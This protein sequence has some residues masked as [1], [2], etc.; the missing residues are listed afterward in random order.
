M[1]LTASLFTPLL[2]CWRSMIDDP[3]RELLARVR[4]PPSFRWGAAT[5]GFQ[6]EGGF[7]VPDGPA[8]HWV[9]W[10]RA[11]R[12]ELAGRAN[13]FW[14]RPEA[15]LDAARAIG[16][17]AFRLSLEWARLE[18]TEG[19]LDDV[20]LDHYVAIVAACW[21]R[22][23]E[24]L[25]TL[26]HFTHPAWLGEDP[27]SGAEG[28]RT[29]ARFADHVRL[30]ADTVGARL[31]G[32]GLPPLGCYVTLNEI[33]ILPLMS[34]VLGVF[35][36]GGI[37]HT[38]RAAEAMDALLCAHIAA[39]DAIHDVHAARGWPAP[40]VT[41]NNFAFG[42]YELD[43]L[44]SDVLTARTRGIAERELP[45]HLT[46][47]RARWYA[48]LDVGPRGEHWID[49]LLR[50]LVGALLRDR[51]PR[52]RAAL[53]ASPRAAKLDA[54]AFD[55]YDPLPERFLRLPGRRAGVGRVWQPIAALWETPPHPAMF[56]WY[57]RQAAE[58][59]LPLMVLENG[60]CSA[61]R[62]DERTVRGDGWTRPEYLRQ[63]L[64]AVAQALDEGL[65]LTAYVHWSIVD[66]YEWGSYLPRFGLHG[67]DARGQLEPLDSMGH[68]SAAILT[69]LIAALKEPG[70]ERRLRAFAPW[71][72]R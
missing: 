13:A 11:A 34:H 6:I 62:G 46:S 8:N 30:V 23:L 15:L 59:G 58:Y 50:P 39:Y 38:R 67:A 14:E 51:L 70:V 19:R 61:R 3:M 29:A 53:Y 5:A 42:L 63:H 22:G 71:R 65:P 64:L 55:Y 35:P 2:L 45:R 17:N 32:R 4:V 7:N 26:H 33:N 12:V 18:P 40:T 47:R 57:L 68:D 56:L 69:E 66:N 37:G 52:G 43:R 28:V 1:A 27:W 31:T 44:I 9:A 60:L 49:G 25:V 36:P 21:E 20:A 48:A 10:E 54:L 72:T 24:P 16:L 41:T